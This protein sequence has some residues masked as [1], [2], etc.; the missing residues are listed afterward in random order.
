MMYNISFVWLGNFAAA[1]VLAPFCF[2]IIA[3]VKAFFAG[4]KGIPLLQL[5]FD[6]FKLMRRGVIY[7]TSVSSV[8]KIAPAVVLASLICAFALLPCSEHASAFSFERDILLF[9]YMLALARA[10]TVLAALDTASSFEGMGSARELHFSI[11]AECAIITMLAMLSIHSSGEIS[12]SGIFQSLGESNKNGGFY[13]MAMLI[14]AVGF[15]LVLLAEN[16][17]VPADDPETHL[18]LTMIHEAMILDYSGPDLGVI[19]YAAALKL[20][21]FCQLFVMMII[22][23]LPFWGV[24]LGVFISSGIIGVVESVMARFRLLKV[25]QFLTGAFALE[26]VA[27]ALLIWEV[28]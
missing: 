3:K 7:S 18:E 14:G 24:W 13:G 11:F 17:R 12:F 28:L 16:C 19:H 26:L 23:D 25:P 5:Y 20:W 6:I 22:P 1:L 10:F 2:G 8:F 21:C 27:L 4:R 15:F 9:I